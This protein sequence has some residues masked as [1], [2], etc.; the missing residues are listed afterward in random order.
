MARRRKKPRIVVDKSALR[1]CSVVDLATL[2]KGHRLLL[3]YGLLYEVWTQ[4]QSGPGNWQR[5]LLKLKGLDFS[6]CRY[7]FRIFE[8]EMKRCV[9]FTRITSSL[10]T[11]DLKRGLETPVSEWPTQDSLI[12]VRQRE[13]DS[14]SLVEHRRKRLR[15]L[16]TTRVQDA[17]RK[18]SLLAAEQGWTIARAFWTAMRDVAVESWHQ[19]YNLLP[20][21][22]TPKSFMFME[23]WL[24]NYQDFRRSLDQG[25]EINAVSDK[26]LFNE[27]LDRE[28][29]L[30]LVRA[31]GLLSKDKQMRETAEAFFPGRSVMGEVVP[32][33]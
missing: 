21:L 3:P 13:S 25:A 12:S 32:A 22:A 7:P 20:K 28:Y 17:L 19:Y 26:V 24:S 2:S 27:A 31:D 10:H 33:G 1:A 11:L 5:L 29:V 9:P 4:D 6:A 8:E 16:N 30:L 14:A 15:A 18:V 23:V